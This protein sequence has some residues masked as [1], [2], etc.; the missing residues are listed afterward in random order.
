MNIYVGGRRG[1]LGG[2]KERVQKTEMGVKRTK[3]GRYR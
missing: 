3:K 2:V 1:I